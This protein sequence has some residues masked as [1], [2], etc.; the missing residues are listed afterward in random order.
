M[1]YELEGLL[2]VK[3]DTQQVS[4]KFKKRE[5]VVETTT[6]N[7][8]T[9]FT[10]QVKLQFTQDRC[11]LIEI[12]EVGDKVKVNFNIKGKGWEKNGTTNYFVNL[13]A[14]R[15]EKLESSDDWV[16]PFV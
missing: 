9:D 10:E 11:D 12:I 3:N 4:D 14:W 8:T 1:S 13:D 16:D 7:G 5:F 6:S 15:I 2:I